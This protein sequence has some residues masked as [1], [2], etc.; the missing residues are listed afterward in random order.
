M[1]RVPRSTLTVLLLL[2]ACASGA[3]NAPPAQPDRAAR[4]EPERV[5]EDSG[6]RTLGFIGTPFYALFKGIGCVASV[7]VATP[8]A[9][10]YGLT[11]RDDRDMVRANLDKGVGA[12]CGGSYALA[13]YA[14]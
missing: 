14:D 7:I 11:D 13:P 6:H 2:G 5:A 12:N 10:G 1:T 4:S 8:V 9:V 3:G